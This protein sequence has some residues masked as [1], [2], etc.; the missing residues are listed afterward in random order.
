MSHRY[1]REQKGKAPTGSNLLRKPLVKIPES[2]V[3]ELVDRNKF[4]LIGRVTNPRVQKTRALVDF[5]LQQWNVVGKIT[6]RD[7]GPSLFQF[8]FESEKDLQTILSR[9]PFHFKKWMLILQ[10]WEPIVSDTFP[11]RIPFWV[12]V[13]GIPLHYWNEKTI[14]AI[15]PVLGSIEVKEAD[16]ARL[17]VL[18]NGL[19]PLIMKMDLQL[20]SGEVVE[21]E[22]EYE[23]LQK[24][25]FLCKSLCHESDDCP[26]R[27]ILRTQSDDVKDI[28]ISQRNTLDSIEES[29]KR[30]EDRKRARQYQSSHQG[31]ARWTN[32]RREERDDGYEKRYRRQSPPPRRKASEE[33]SESGFEENRRRYNDRSLSVRARSPHR[34][35]TALRGYDGES[36][37]IKSHGRGNS[38]SVSS[39]RKRI[40]PVR[41]DLSKSSQSPATATNNNQRRTRISSRLSDPRGNGSGEDRV[42]AKE[43][44]SVNTQRTIRSE[45]EGRSNEGEQPP[46]LAPRNLEVSL[47]P[48][49]CDS[50]TCPSSSTIF[51]TG[52]LGPGERS[53]IR[54]LSEDRIHVS[55]RLGPIDSETT[56]E[57]EVSDDLPPHPNMT[58]KAAGKRVA[59][60]GTTSSPQ[61][62]D[63]SRKR[64]V[65]KVNS[66]PRRKLMMDA[67]KAGGKAPRKTK[68]KPPSTKIIPASKR[69][70]SGFH[71][72]QKSLP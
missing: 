64:R 28:G 26:N 72:L 48:R 66:S 59:R 22:L 62:K 6:G 4:T 65:C 23:Y 52:R 24:H 29:K 13:H 18:V 39:P 38:R 25:C 47:P 53:P 49:F 10:R 8:G 5:F 41:E 19:Q 37:S 68:S 42:S 14:D 12:N 35:S 69:K 51:E 71:P 2:D 50:I 67:F 9:A 55:L 54:T 7:L 30:Q 1:S 27:D 31:G 20:P 3:S 56:A 36:S 21:I 44:L 34:R 63:G 33:N 40:S 58:E 61:Q 57:T 70:E 32:Y 11:S 45:L 43:R 60:R 17:R 16:K 46:L 15:G